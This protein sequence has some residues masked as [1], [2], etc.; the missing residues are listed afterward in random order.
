MHAGARA[1]GEMSIMAKSKTVL[2]K[3]DEDMH[4]KKGSMPMGKGK[5]KKGSKTSGQGC[6]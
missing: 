6:K 4:D 3:K 1:E 5:A 2:S